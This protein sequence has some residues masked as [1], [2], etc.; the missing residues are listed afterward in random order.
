MPTHNSNAPQL[1]TIPEI[2]GRTK[3]LPVHMPAIRPVLSP[4]GF[5]QS[6]EANNNL[7]LQY[8]S[9]HDS[10]HRQY[11]TDGRQVKSHL[12]ALI[13][14]LTYLRF[15]INVP[16][17]VTTPTQITEFLGLLV[18]STLKFARRETPPYQDG[19]QNNSYRR[20][21]LQHASWRRL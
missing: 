4:M 8:G 13:F 10:I 15:I 17:S 19:G 12:K 1:P 14:I 5:H 11:T 16:K 7:S 3:A 9:V 21:R 18:N 2:H 20:H 6:D